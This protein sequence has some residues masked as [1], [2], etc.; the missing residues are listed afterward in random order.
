VA[1]REGDI[2]M[3]NDTVNFGKGKIVTDGLVFRLDAN[4]PRS[5]TGDGNT[6]DWY[7]LSAGTAYDATFKSG[8]DSIKASGV[9]GTET[10]IKF[11]QFRTTGVGETGYIHAEVPSGLRN[12]GILKDENSSFSIEALFRPKYFYYT[13]SGIPNSGAP[14]FGNT[15]HES[16]CK[17]QGLITTGY[18]LEML[19]RGT[20]S[21][22]STTCFTDGIDKNVISGNVGIGGDWQHVTLCYD[23]STSDFKCYANGVYGEEGASTYPVVAEDFIGDHSAN[24]GAFFIGGD[25]YKYGGNV[26]VSVVSCYNRSLSSG[27]A[28]QNYQALKYRVI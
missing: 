22:D 8:E 14:I 11:F 24:T 7:D 16:G 13:E 21:S 18:N 15:F 28:Y 25:P 5:Y 19:V 26:D 6:Y 27:E 9:L 2:D 10:D 1:L 4:S 12:E 20:I 3:S 17:N 23:A